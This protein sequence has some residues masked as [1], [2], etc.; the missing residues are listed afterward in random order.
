MKRIAATTILAIVLGIAGASAQDLR[1]ACRGDYL[2]FCSA[3]RPGT[4]EVRKCFRDNVERISETCRGAIRAS[5]EA[6][7]R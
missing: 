1:S 5:G 4:P 7:K 2:K 3:H 6:D